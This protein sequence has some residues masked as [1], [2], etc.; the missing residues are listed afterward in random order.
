MIIFE[1][2]DIVQ[3]DIINKKITKDGLAMGGQIGDQN[4]CFMIYQKIDL[5]EF[6]SYKDFQGQKTLIKHGNYALVIK[7]IGRPDNINQSLDV[8][9]MYDIYEVFTTK[10]SKRQVFAYNLKKAF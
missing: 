7:K 3:F 6:P 1:P 8:W 10:L 4:D 9:S 5:E 2:G